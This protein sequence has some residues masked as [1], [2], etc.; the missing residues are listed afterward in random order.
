MQQPQMCHSVHFKSGTPQWWWGQAGGCLRAEG[1][2]FPTLCHPLFPRKDRSQMLLLETAWVVFFSRLWPNPGSSSW[3]E[4]KFVLSDGW[5]GPR[6]I[7]AGSG[8]TV[9]DTVS[10][11]RK[12]R[13]RFFLFKI[14][15]VTLVVMLPTFRLGLPT[16]GRPITDLPRVCLLHD[17]KF[18]K[19]TW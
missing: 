7:M 18:H 13:Q 8:K 3:R 1:P 5:G 12:Q 15:S 17:S 19:L 11:V 6:A 16:A 4:E 2:V 9:G 14:K 10:V